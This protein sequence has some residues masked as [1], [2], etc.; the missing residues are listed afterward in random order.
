MNALTKAAKQNIE[1][2]EKDSTIV[3]IFCYTLI[4]VVTVGFAVVFVQHLAK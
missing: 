4:S 2:N 1:D 3:N